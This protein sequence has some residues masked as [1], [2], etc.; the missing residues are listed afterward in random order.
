MNKEKADE[1]IDGLTVLCQGVRHGPRDGDR[2]AYQTN[3]DAVEDKLKT[4]IQAAVTD[5]PEA[6]PDERA[7]LDALQGAPKYMT[8]LVVE[9]EAEGMYKALVQAAIS[10]LLER[11]VVQL[12]D[13]MRLSVVPVP[14]DKTEAGET[15]RVRIAVAVGAEGS[16]DVGGY[17]RPAARGTT[18]VSTDWESSQAALNE[19]RD[20]PGA[21]G[22]PQVHFIEADIPLPTSVTVEGEVVK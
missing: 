18:T 11:G 13:Y 5:K 1:L 20:A 10:R 2:R 8:H 4:L 17:G 19:L 14:T 3:I 7:V 9:L 16:W 6:D 21:P 15:V 22:F 12:N